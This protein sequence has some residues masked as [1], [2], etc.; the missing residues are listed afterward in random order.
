MATPPARL[1]LMSPLAAWAW[2]TIS[3]NERAPATNVALRSIDFSSLWVATL[4]SS[5]NRRFRLPGLG[6]A[7]TVSNTWGSQN[8]RDASEP[9]VGCQPSRGEYGPNDWAAT[10]SGA[11]TSTDR[12]GR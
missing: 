2:G 6:R 4:R 10:G 1:I 5:L 9:A 3:T 8:G 11:G 7:P 12:V